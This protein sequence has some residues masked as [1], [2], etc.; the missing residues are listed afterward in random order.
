[1]TINMVVP[2]YAQVV[3]FNG[4]ES[5]EVTSTIP[6]D[7]TS[8]S[9]EG[10]T[11]QGSP[12]E[13]SDDSAPLILPL[14]AVS[15][16]SVDTKSYWGLVLTA[17]DYYE[18]ASTS[19]KKL[20]RYPAKS[21]LT[22]R[23]WDKA[24]RWVFVVDSTGTTRFVQKKHIEIIPQRTLNDKTLYYGLMTQ[25]RS[26]WSAPSGRSHN[27]GV[28]TKGSL[29]KY[30]RWTGNNTWVYT[31]DAKGRRMFFRG[32]TIKALP[33][34]T[35]TDT[36]KYSGIALK[37]KSYYPGPTTTVTASG[38]FG[39]GRT[40]SYRKWTADGKWFY[41]SD[42]KGNVV[43]FTKSDIEILPKQTSTDK[44][45]YWAIVL[46]NRSFWSAP[47]IR[48]RNRGI[49][50]AGSLVSYR[51]WTSSGS[52]VYATDG[53]GRWI[54]FKGNDLE[55]VPGKTSTDKKQYSAVVGTARSYYAGPS[56]KATR[57]RAL[58]AGTPVSYWKWTAD[59]SWVYTYDEQGRVMFFRGNN[60]TPITVNVS[61]NAELNLELQKIISR[62]TTSSM[63][64]DQKLAACYNHVVTGY[65]YAARGSYPAKG[66]ETSYAL[67]MIKDK[68]GNCYSYAALFGFLAQALGY[69][70]RIISGQV[71]MANGGWGAHGWV[72]IRLGGATYV[73]DP[74]GQRS[75]GR[76]M[77]MMPIGN[78]LLTYKR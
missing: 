71:G 57:L 47:S 35:A 36:A 3:S 7:V 78:T 23:H 76:N 43:F 1:M 68:A 54:Y 19:S 42:G 14:S 11:G 12:S 22:F 50:Y 17:C 10:S 29:V 25:N 21:T 41:G 20:G 13:L 77:Y 4:S 59:G 34:Q 31:L 33:R 37:K 15:A 64:Q 65:S 66:W 72:E 52:W 62:V 48:S 2:V 75:L 70:A 8:D 28:A 51:K 30:Y 44:T 49:A 74:E 32:D 26:F 61:S 58:P 5:I 40:I 56:T 60:L 45:V 46:K 38:R 73:C 27:R 16:D 6:Q 18:S 63:T 39:I 9:S 53:Q 24:G 55:V 69:D 67:N